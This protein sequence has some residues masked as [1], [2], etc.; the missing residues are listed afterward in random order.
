[1]GDSGKHLQG[2]VRQAGHFDEVAHLGRHNR[3]RPDDAVQ[4]GVIDD[5]ADCGRIVFPE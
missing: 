2:D 4:G 5:A 3:R 1:V